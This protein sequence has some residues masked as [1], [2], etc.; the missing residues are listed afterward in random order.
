MTPATAAN[1]PASKAF[2]RYWRV[3]SLVLPLLIVPAIQWG[4][5]INRDL[6]DLRLQVRE[7]STDGGH[8]RKGATELGAEL[9][10]MRTQLEQFRVDVVQR[11]ATLEARLDKSR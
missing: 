2:D 6:D 9:R 3:L 10:A 5:Q 11:I 4:A 8:D 7:L 1:S